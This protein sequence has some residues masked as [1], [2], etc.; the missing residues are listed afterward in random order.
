MS[1]LNSRGKGIEIDEE[2]VV[3]ETKTKTKT[4]NKFSS[5]TYIKSDKD[6]QILTPTPAPAPLTGDLLVNDAFDSMTYALASKLDML[7]LFT[8]IHP[9]AER[10][11]IEIKQSIESIGFFGQEKKDV[12]E[13]EVLN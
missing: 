10:N 8:N 12:E 13:E 2:L 3:T 9:V 7:H 6:N 1:F 11:I 4:K 5:S